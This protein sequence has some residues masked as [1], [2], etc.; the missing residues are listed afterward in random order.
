MPAISDAV[1]NLGL[2][3]VEAPAAATPAPIY[4]DEH[5]VGA[6]AGSVNPE[7]GKPYDSPYDEDT[8]RQLRHHFEPNFLTSFSALPPPHFSRISQ[9]RPAPRA[10]CAPLYLA[11]VLIGC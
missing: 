4:E 6:A 7:Q 5:E 3:A 1:T 11:P 8:V 2:Q 10:P 9:F